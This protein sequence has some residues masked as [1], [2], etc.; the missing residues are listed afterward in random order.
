MKNK[1]AKDIQGHRKML[2]ENFNVEADA[3]LGG[4]GV[5]VAADRIDLAGNGLGGARFRALEN[6]VLDEVRNAVPFGI[7]VARAGLQPNADRDRTDVR[8]LL[9]ND[10]E[11]IRQNLT[12]N[13]ASF[14]YH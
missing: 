3:L 4:E 13:A 10:G 14:F 2:V 11:A 1:I 8:H 5:H 9:G 12:T 6:H 7:F